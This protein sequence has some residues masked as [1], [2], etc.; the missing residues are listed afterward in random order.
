MKKL[1][2]P[3]IITIFKKIEKIAGLIIAFSGKIFIHIFVS[4]IIMSV[5][6]YK[7]NT[8]PVAL[9]VCSFSYNSNYKTCIDVDCS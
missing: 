1:L 3:S 2:H 5:L 8:Q 9:Y 6:I 7:W 4:D